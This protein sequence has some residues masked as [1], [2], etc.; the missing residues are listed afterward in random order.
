MPKTDK[1]FLTNFQKNLNS[2]NKKATNN[3]INWYTIVIKNI[4]INQYI[5]APKLSLV[6]PKILQRGSE[7]QAAV[8]PVIPKTTNIFKIWKL[9]LIPHLFLILS[10][11]LGIIDINDLLSKFD[12]NSFLRFFCCSPNMRGHWYF[13]IH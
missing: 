4:L 6:I 10:N 7:I 8:D 3:N 2:P 12:A 11:I 5:I 9:E 1:N 13:L